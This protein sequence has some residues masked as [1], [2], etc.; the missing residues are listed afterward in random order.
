MFWE[1]VLDTVDVA[2]RILGRALSSKES[3]EFV[4]TL[5]PRDA[6][7]CLEL[8]DRV[9]RYSPPPSMFLHGFAGFSELSPRRRF[10]EDV[11]H[12]QRGTP[13]G[14]PLRLWVHDHSSQPKPFTVRPRGGRGRHVL[15]HGPRSFGSRKVRLGS[16]IPTREADLFAFGLLAF[17]VFCPSCSKRSRNA[18]ISVGSH[19][20]TA[21]RLSH[22]PRM[23]RCDS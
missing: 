3:R 7:L 15:V 14:L 11:S 12:K 5:G 23:D 8:L 2:I 21:V 17:Q 18:L 1:N 10:E 6:G 22:N 4:C 9:S 16:S 19:R 20:E 13:S